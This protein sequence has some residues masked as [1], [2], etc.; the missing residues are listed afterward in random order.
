MA[1]RGSRR[2][3]PDDEIDASLSQGSFI[4]HVSWFDADPFQIHLTGVDID[5]EMIRIG[6]TWFGLDDKQSTCLIA[7]GIQY[8]R[9]QVEDKGSDLLQT[10]VLRS[11]AAHSVSYDVIVFDVDNDDNQSPL[12]C[13]HPV[14]I[15]HGVLQHVRQLLSGESGLFVLNFATRDQ[16]SR[17]RDECLTALSANFDH[18][19]TIKVEDDINEIMLASQGTL[20]GVQSNEKLFDK[21]LSTDFDTAEVL[22]KLKIE[23]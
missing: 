5:T 20:D 8:L 22:S 4:E 12:R 13:P 17:Y 18:L 14:F 19:S 9:Q 11:L 6:K 21:N 10:I 1:A 3:C 7:D 16:T 15:E 23:K 2:W